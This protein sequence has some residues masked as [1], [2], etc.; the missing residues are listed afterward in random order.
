MALYDTAD[1]LSK[2]LE[3]AK[4]PTLDGDMSATKWYGLLTDAQVYWLERFANFCPQSQ[5]GV[6]VLMVT[7]DGGLTYYI[8]NAGQPREFF[9]GIELRHG[10]GGDMIYVG[11]DF[12][13]R[14]DL[15]QEGA[16]FRVPNGIT[17]Q[18]PNGLYARHVPM[19]GV[20]DAG[21]QPVLK[22]ARARQLLVY[23][24]CILYASRG[25][26][27]DP[28][29][30]QNLEDEYFFGDPQRGDTGLLGTLRNQFPVTLPVSLDG[31]SRWYSSGDLG[32]RR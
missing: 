32:P 18:F 5:W 12:D 21:T 29:P 14:S 17:R 26:F 3:A 4:R 24:A 27:F 11:P 15:V 6:P 10:R 2:C 25:G 30:Y 13:N 7:T 19:P 23:R 8:D 28:K 31:N 9:G 1:L 22:P 20:I 16:V